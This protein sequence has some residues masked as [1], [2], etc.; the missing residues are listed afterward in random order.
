MLKQSTPAKR[1]TENADCHTMAQH[2]RTLLYSL[3][4]W[5][6]NR[7]PM[8]A[9]MNGVTKLSPPEF[10][11]QPDVIEFTA[12]Y[13]AQLMH[14]TLQ[15]ADIA[16]DGDCVQSLDAFMVACACMAVK[17]HVETDTPFSEALEL[18]GRGRTLSRKELVLAEATILQ[19]TDWMRGL[20]DDGG[21]G[22]VSSCAPVDCD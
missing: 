5:V 20:D 19:A 14:C 2:S 1:A 11:S 8:D 9:F 6:T 7:I 21:G 12:S 15:N 17:V 18:L 3:N 10:H 22:D 13:A 16:P 4:K